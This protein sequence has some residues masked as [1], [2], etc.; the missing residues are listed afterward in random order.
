MIKKK[1]YEIFSADKI[2]KKKRIVVIKHDAEIELL[3]MLVP[4]FLLLCNKYL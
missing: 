3:T 4:F 1:C 2:P